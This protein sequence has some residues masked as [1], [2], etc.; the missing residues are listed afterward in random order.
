MRESM[1]VLRRLPF[2]VPG[3][4]MPPSSHR[5][6]VRCRRLLGGPGGIPGRCT[7]LRRLSAG[8]R[9][10]RA[11]AASVPPRRRCGRAPIPSPTAAAP[12]TRPPLAR[13]RRHRLRRGVG[14]I[15]RRSSRSSSSARPPC[16]PPRPH[17]PARRQQQPPPRRRHRWL[18]PPPPRRYTRCAAGPAASRPPRMSPP[19]PRGPPR[20]RRRPPGQHRLKQRLQEQQ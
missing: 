4:R 16:P 8:R 3:A 9:Q 20:R 11:F 12:R 18:A 1:H 13:P 2:R 19:S 10:P 6:A 5:V 17:C 15:R 14:Y 7:L